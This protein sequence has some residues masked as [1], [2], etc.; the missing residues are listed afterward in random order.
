MTEEV[1]AHLFEAFIAT[2]PFGTGLG[3]ATCLSTGTLNGRYHGS[4]WPRS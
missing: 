3:L 1:K 4:L 2:K